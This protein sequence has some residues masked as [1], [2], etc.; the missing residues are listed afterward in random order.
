MNITGLQTMIGPGKATNLGRTTEDNGPGAGF[1]DVYKKALS[2]VNDKKIEADHMVT[3]LVSGQHSNI[4]ETMIAMEKS[5][6][7]FKL[8]SKVQSKVLEAYKEVIKTPV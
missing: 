4:H 7:S 8:L 3:G 1:A 6:I 2:A 5:S